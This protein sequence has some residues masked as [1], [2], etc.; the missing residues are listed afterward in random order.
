MQVLRKSTL[1]SS[2]LVG[3]LS[4]ALLPSITVADDAEQ[5]KKRLEQMIGP[6]AKDAK[7]TQSEINGLYQIQLGLTVV[8]MSADGKYMM[9]GNMIDLANDKNLTRAVKA[10]TRKKLLSAI[11]EKGMIVYPAKDEKHTVTVFTDIDCPYCKKLHKEIPALNKAGVTV[12]YLAYPRTG[13]NSPSFNKA[14]S[15]WCADDKAKTMDDAMV[16]LPPAKK[17]CDSPVKEHMIRAQMMEVNGTPN[18]ILD[19]GNAIPGYAPAIE[20]IK[21][22]KAS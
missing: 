2:I 4:L 21:M 18:M 17:K 9:N 1:L 20:I 22:L 12:R 19:N 11:D 13:F 3:A 16:G 10:E 14:V 15:V 8:Y 7:V 5:V 6:D